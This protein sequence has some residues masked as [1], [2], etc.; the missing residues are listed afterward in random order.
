[1]ATTT[2][3]AELKDFYSDVFYW[4]KNPDSNGDDGFYDGLVL[5][6]NGVEKGD[7][8]SLLTDLELDDEVVILAGSVFRSDFPDAGTPFE[9]F[10]NDWRTA[11]SKVEFTVS[12]PKGRFEA[13][14]A[15]ILAAGG[16]IRHSDG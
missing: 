5:M 8:F 7:E 13:I 3:G 16:C 6:V 14:S 10:F 9:S 12:L 2:N 1:M 4:V 15:E 11:Q